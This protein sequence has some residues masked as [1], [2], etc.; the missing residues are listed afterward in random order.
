MTGSGPKPD[1][2]HLDIDEDQ[3]DR[4]DSFLA[5]RLH[6]SRSHVASLIHHGLVVIDGAPVRKSY[7]PQRGDRITVSIPPA[8][9]VEIRPEDIPVEVIFEDEDLLVVDKPAG[10]VVHPAPGNR[11]GTLVNALLHHA[12]RLSS[13]GL[14]DR[15]GIVHRIDKDTS[16]LLVVAKSDYAHR[17]LARDLARRRFRRSYLAAAWGHIGV[18]QVTVDLPIGRDPKARKRM[19]VVEGGRRAI[20]HVRRL[21]RWRAADLLAVRLETGRTHQIRVHLRARGHP[22]VMDP[23]YGH[24]WERGLLGAGGRWADE[25]ARLCGRLF[26]HA[27]R[28]SFQHP[29]GD[30]LL[31]FSSSL[32]EP[33]RSSA[34]WARETS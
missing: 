12:G 4:L 25:F 20:T 29:R 28:L 17:C 18:E 7:R 21:E 14:P 31:S 27:A 2:H 16:G 3:D 24:G 23:V 13:L 33:L 9:S 19:A 30:E 34:K 10:L 11:S 8:R 22:I 6:L 26:L 32:P 15:P 1:I 5:D